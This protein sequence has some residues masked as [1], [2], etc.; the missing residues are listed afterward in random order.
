MIIFDMIMTFYI[1]W[2]ELTIITT[3]D[4]LEIIFNKISEMF[5]KPC[6]FVLLDHHVIVLSFFDQLPTKIV[7][8]SLRFLIH[9]NV[10]PKKFIKFNGFLLLL[11]CFTN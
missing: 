5:I 10:L 8:I 3:S 9:S 6:N 7:M 11:N 2:L 1:H 4:F